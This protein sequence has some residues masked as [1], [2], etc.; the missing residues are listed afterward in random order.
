MAPFVRSWRAAQSLDDRVFDIINVIVLSGALLLVL[1]PL[2]FV[3]IASFSGPDRIYAGD[4]WLLPKDAT[5]EGYARIF[6]DPAIWI[7][8]RNSALYAVL[9]TLISVTLILTGGYALSRNDLY[10]RNIFT[11]F[12]VATMFFDGGLIPRYLLVRDLHLLNTIWAVVLPGAVGVWNLII[13]RTFFQ[14][15]IPDEL[16]EAAFIDG[17]SNFQFF[18]KIALPLSLP[19]IAVMVL[20]HVVGNWNAFFDALIYLTDE[21]LY[22]LQLVLRNIVT[23]SNVAA[24]SAMLTDIESYAAQQ[25]V[26]ELI[27]YGMI[28][29]AS[30]PLLIF[31][32]FVQ[33]YFVKGL[34]IG[35]IKG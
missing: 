24:Q 26:A 25:R 17:A 8:F 11:L 19:L 7:G 3:V 31:Y 14:T 5:L 18:W 32:P 23:Q 33:K 22:P 15:T 28:V 13:A 9:G 34:T 10:G 16:R 12:F 1:Y 6:R 29:I 2:Y 30:A 4:V 21:R 35:A 20:I 27:K